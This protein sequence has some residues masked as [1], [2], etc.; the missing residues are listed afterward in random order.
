MLGVFG[1]RATIQPHARRCSEAG[2]TRTC[3]R[4]PG[5]ARHCMSTVPS[6][7]QW[8]C[9]GQGHGCGSAG[10]FWLSRKGCINGSRTLR[11]VGRRAGMDVSDKFPFLVTKL[12]PYYDR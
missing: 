5:A 12:S 11:R 6:P 10:L 9:H 7:L 8:F 3:A 4:V 1:N 2:G